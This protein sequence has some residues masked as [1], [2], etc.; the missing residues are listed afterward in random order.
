ML[1]MTLMEFIYEPKNG[2][3]LVSMEPVWYAY[4]S[5]NEHLEI[6]ISEKCNLNLTKVPKFSQFRDLF[7]IQKCA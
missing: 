2:L 7:I 1:F 6:V 5:P 4:Y 3:D